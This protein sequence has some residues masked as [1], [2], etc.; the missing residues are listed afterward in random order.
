MMSQQN[1][2]K[3][4]G[5]AS[6]DLNGGDGAAIAMSHSGDR[7]VDLLLNEIDER[8]A[9]RNSV[10]PGEEEAAAPAGRSRDAGPSTHAHGDEAD[11]QPPAGE[12]AHQEALDE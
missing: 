5:R 8:L 7:E 11:S 9:Q 6:V 3:S 2:L 4:S 1:T 10:L 12:G